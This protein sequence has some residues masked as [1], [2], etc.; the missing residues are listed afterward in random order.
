MKGS[1]GIN[2]FIQLTCLIAIPPDQQIANS[3]NRHKHAIPKTD[4]HKCEQQACGS[5]EVRSF[6]ERC[7]NGDGGGWH[8][9]SVS[10]PEN[11]R[12]ICVLHVFTCSQVLKE[13]VTNE[14]RQRSTAAKLGV[15]TIRLG[16][17]CSEKRTQRH[18]STTH[19]TTQPQ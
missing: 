4:I 11:S 10:K 6:S 13:H 19:N 14:T 12:K 2:S 8:T 17:C 7:Q 9:A 16:L 15:F 1:S 3:Q 5:E 18:W